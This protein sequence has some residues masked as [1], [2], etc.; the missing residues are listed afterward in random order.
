MTQPWG[1]FQHGQHRD[2]D[3]QQLWGDAEPIQ[4]LLELGKWPW[5]HH[6]ALRMAS[7]GQDLHP[8]VLAV[9]I[10]VPQLTGRA[11]L[12]ART[13]HGIT[14]AKPRDTDQ[15]SRRIAC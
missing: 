1:G 11:T 2:L 12:S 10:S 7:T 9:A 13:S 15:A 3:R 14:V 6:A 8:Q 4:Q 5:R